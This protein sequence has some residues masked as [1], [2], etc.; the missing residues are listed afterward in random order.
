[1]PSS[2][3]IKQSLVERGFLSP[4]NH[5]KILKLYKSN[6][7]GMDALLEVVANYVKY[8]ADIRNLDL[9]GNPGFMATI[10][11]HV[12]EYLD[13]FFAEVFDLRKEAEE[14]ALKEEK[15]K[16]AKER[17]LPEEKDQYV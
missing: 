10:R 15:K 14:V 8:S 16:D 17:G 4:E 7:E 11:Y 3:K 6:P 2:L 12:V 1:M 9:K 5:E 13:D